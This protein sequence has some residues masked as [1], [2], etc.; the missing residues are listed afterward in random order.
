LRHAM[1]W[2]NIIICSNVMTT[3]KLDVLGASW[4]FICQ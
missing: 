4:Q 2:M 3:N 1:T